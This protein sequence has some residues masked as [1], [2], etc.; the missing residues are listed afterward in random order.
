HGPVV[1]NA[2]N[3]LE[4][5]DVAQDPASWERAVVVDLARGAAAKLLVDLRQIPARE[6]RVCTFEILHT[7]QPELLHHPVLQHAV[8]SL[9]APLGLRRRRRDDLDPEPVARL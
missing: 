5:E 6:K 9:D 8:T 2:A 4:H 1:L 3:V 7:L